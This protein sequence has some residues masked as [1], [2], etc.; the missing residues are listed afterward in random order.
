M[1]IRDSKNYTCVIGKLLTN[2]MRRM[3]LNGSLKNFW[4]GAKTNILIDELNKKKGRIES[5]EKEIMLIQQEDDVLSHR[6]SSF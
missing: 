1:W 2:T 4:K 6:I 5:I 3:G